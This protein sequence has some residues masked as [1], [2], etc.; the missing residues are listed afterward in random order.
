MVEVAVNDDQLDTN[1]LFEKFS[2]VFSDNVQCVCWIVKDF[3][4]NLLY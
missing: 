4:S 1:R 3:N 2:L